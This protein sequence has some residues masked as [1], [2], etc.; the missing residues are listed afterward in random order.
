[1]ARHAGPESEKERAHGV[2][3]FGVRGREMERWKK[4]EGGKERQ[5]TAKR[6]EGGAMSKK[7]ATQSVS[8][9]DSSQVAVKCRAVSSCVELYGSYI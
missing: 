3:V 7:R 4:E 2:G 1:M 5:G 9:R 8:P 6:E